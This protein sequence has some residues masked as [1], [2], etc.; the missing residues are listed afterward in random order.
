VSNAFSHVVGDDGV[1]EVVLDKPPVNALNGAEWLALAALLQ[2]L[3]VDSRVRVLI[4]RAEGRGFCAGVDVKELAAD[5][6]L[7][8]LVERGN[9]MTF[10]AVYEFRVPVLC[11]VHGFVLGG[12]VGIAGAADGI[13]AADDAWFA[14]PEIDRGALGAS[15]W[16]VR[17]VGQQKA[18]MLFFRAARLSALEAHRL[19]AVEAVVPRAS[20]LDAVRG[21]ARE[22]AA[23]SPR[24]V[25]LAKESMNLVEHPDPTR[26]YRTEQ[27]FTAE[28]Y[29]SRESQEARDAF[30]EKRE[31]RFE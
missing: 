16:L 29:M 30:V 23:K 26:M 3:S 11:A 5:P 18:R 25:E 31:P 12:G 20:L 1:A 22:I 28:L 7:L 15:T 21:C 9:H 8:P 17:M 10:K 2:S 27:G 13:F 6:S 4:I 14:L 24:A 19:G